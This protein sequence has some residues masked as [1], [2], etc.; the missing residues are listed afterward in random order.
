MERSEGLVRSEEL[1]WSGTV[2]RSRVKQQGSVG[3][4]TGGGELGVE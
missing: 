1:E 2:E 3:A 4:G